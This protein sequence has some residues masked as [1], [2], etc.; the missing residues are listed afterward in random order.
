ML[1]IYNTFTQKKEVFSPI[2]PGKIKMYVCGITVYD[3]CHI[4]HARTFVAF[5]VIARFLRYLG[6]EVNFVRNITDIDD[7]IIARAI[8]AKCSVNELTE[9]FIKA[10]HEDMQSLNIE[11]VSSEPRATQAMDK[12]QSMI[13]ILMDK[14]LAYQGAT[15]D[16]YF[17]VANY[18]SYGQLA[19]KQLDELEAGHRVAREEA[20][21]NPLDFVLWK[22]AKPGEPAWP[23]PW[24]EGRPGWHIE[25]SAMATDALGPTIDIHGGGADL[26]FPHHENERAQSEGATGKTFVNTW[27]HVGFVQVNKEKMSKS[28]NN[29]FTIRDV[30]Q[31]YDAEVIRYF[32]MSSHYRSQIN[33]SEEAMDA[34]KQ[35]LTRL[36]TALSDLDVESAVVTNDTVFQYASTQADYQ[37][38][39]EVAMEDDFNT[40]QAMAVLFDLSKKINTLKITNT[41]AAVLLARSLKELGKV[42]GILQRDVGDFFKGNE[43]EEAPT[44]WIESMIAAREKARLDKNWARADEIRSELLSKK[45]ILE[46]KAGTTT[47]RYE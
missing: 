17:R 13:Q 26:T 34:A 6:F 44:A 42:L 40:P 2:H 45:V 3:Y 20:K 27:M 19:H 1:E 10:M 25:C 16:V 18:K 43:S 29:F 35:S 37:V 28:L 8:E 22:P 5:D 31:R 24:G 14:G 39:F 46:D 7:K 30:K 21:E 15:G 47:W 4:G 23:S 9:T 33:Y 11:P 32:L 12:M 38:R 41:A 36:Y